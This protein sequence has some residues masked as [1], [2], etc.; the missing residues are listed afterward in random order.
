MAEASG[1]GGVPRLVLRIEGATILVLAVLLDA[2][3]GL[4]WWLFAALF[5]APDLSFLG[6]LAGPRAG[7]IIY[8]AV[9]T[10][11]A[12]LLPAAAG[13]LLPAFVLIPLALIWAARIGMD[14]ALGYGLKYAAGFWLH[15]SRPPHV[16]R[17]S[18]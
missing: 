12:P 6:Y 10:L 1:V 18:A 2:E 11:V 17:G 5:L 9:H 7:A 14:R 13:M 3:V 16:G 15:A 4:S 8:N